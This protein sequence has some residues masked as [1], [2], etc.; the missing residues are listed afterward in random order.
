MRIYI[1][2]PMRGIKDFNFPKFDEVAQRLRSEGHTVYSPAEHDRD[3]YGDT[4]K[5]ETGDEADLENG[6]NLADAF[7][8]DTSIITHYVNA[9]VFLPGYAKS[10]GA[11]CEMSIAKLMGRQLLDEYLRPLGDVH[12][13]AMRTFE[14][15]ATRDVDNDKYDL[16]GFI[17]PLALE[18]FGQYMHE[19]RKQS[20]G[21]IRDS[22]NWQKG[23]P[24]AAYRKGLIRHVRT[25]WALWRGWPVK[26]ERV[27][28]VLKE[29]TLEDALCAILFNVQGMLHELV[30]PQPV[31]PNEK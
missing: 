8:W 1:A 28:G 16:E 4:F 18:R 2:G 13:K 21:S 15:G 11:M 20:D 9:V 30:K 7:Q 31:K 19:H 5:S 3:V 23:I 10:Q 6:F 25:A 27:G 17:S 22:D 29:P 14:T 12:A 24:L 26:Q